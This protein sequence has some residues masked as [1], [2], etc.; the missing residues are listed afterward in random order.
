MNQ[1]IDI[2]LNHTS[3]RKYK[4]V[5]IS[6]DIKEIIIRS[7]QMAPSSSH[8]QA[9]MM[10]EIKNKALREMFF[11][12][13]GGQ[14]W[15]L[16]APLVILY[17]ADLHRAENYFNGLDKKVL[18]NLESYTVAVTDA[19]IAMQKGLIAAQLM[20]LGGV[21]VGGIR[22]NVDKICKT[23]NLPQKVAPLFLLC[24]G[25]P[26][27]SVGIKPRLPMEAVYCVDGYDETEQDNLIRDYNETV[28]DYYLN[29]SDGKMSESWSQRCG[30]LLMAKTRYEVGETLREKGL[31]IE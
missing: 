13:S 28:K 29:R 20:G 4:D 21:V 26:D 23:L 16:S 1:A 17:C 2:L 22:N 5:A 8:F 27:E 30:R 12:I 6:Q 15:I 9:Y 14:K 18:S 31:A 7:S 10:I 11:E 24:L 3:I 25:Y 19:S